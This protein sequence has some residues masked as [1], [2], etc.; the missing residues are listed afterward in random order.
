MPPDDDLAE[1]TRAALEREA[2]PEPE[3]P[4]VSAGTPEGVLRELMQTA[5]SESVRVQAAKALSERR[6]ARRRREGERR[7]PDWQRR[8][9]EPADADALEALDRNVAA[10]VF[11]VAAGGGDLEPEL[12]AAVAAV[13]EVLE[14]ARNETVP[15][16]AEAV[17]AQ[18]PAPEPPGDANG[19]DASE[20]TR[21]FPAGKVEAM[22]GRS[23]RR[24]PPQL[25]YSY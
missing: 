12:P 20:G 1:L 11:A 4:G 14:Q 24:R 2:E 18:E 7:E 6:E 16:A 25:P 21:T 9:P 13:R 3:E 23:R 15:L 8:R 10:L 5:D 22:A 19:S 17:E